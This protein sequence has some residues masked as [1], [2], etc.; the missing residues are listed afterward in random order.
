M[1]SHVFQNKPSGEYP[2]Q[3]TKESYNTSVLVLQYRTTIESW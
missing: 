3:Q 2:P 1:G